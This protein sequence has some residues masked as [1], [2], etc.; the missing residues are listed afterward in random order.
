[1]RPAQSGPLQPAGVGPLQVN[2]KLPLSGQRADEGGG[3]LPQTGAQAI[4][5]IAVGLEAAGA[6]ARANGGQNVLRAA[7]VLPRHH[8]HRPGGRAE[9]SPPPS[10][11]DSGGALPDRVVEQDGNTVPGKNSKADPRLI[12]NQPVRLKFSSL[13]GVWQNIRPGHRTDPGAVNLMV[14]H[15]SVYIRPHR[16]TEAGKVFPHISWVVPPSGTQVQALPGRRGDAPQPGGK[17]VGH[18]GAEAV[19][20][21]KGNVFDCFSYDLHEISPILIRFRWVWDGPLL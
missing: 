8:L 6:D 12:A 21:V 14:F 17:A 5:D 9:G 15:Q 13:D 4:G 19:A 10:G 1:M 16:S 2:G 18:A 11:V 20:S 3:V 7:A